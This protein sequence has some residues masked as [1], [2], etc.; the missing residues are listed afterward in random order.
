MLRRIFFTGLAAIIP[1]VITIYIVV[2]LFNFADGILGKFINRYLYE[3]FG[4]RIP[5]LGIII[6]ILTIFLAGFILKLSRM[7]IARGLEKLFCKI[8]IVKSVYFPIKRIVDFLFLQQP[9]RFKGV[10]LVEY[11]RKGIYSIGFVTNENPTQ[12]KKKME[13]K[14]YNIFIP[15][16]PSPL[17]GFTII[18]PEEEIIFLDI[19]I[20]EA[21][22][23]VVS[24]GMIGP[25]E[26][27]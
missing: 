27:I 13:K 17:T 2:G 8:P 1:L 12:F 24:G 25:E 20:E 21:I 7:R 9:E 22:K 6:S 5:G 11:P 14:L 4:Y 23:V 16:S 26:K 15:S 10:V 18:V 3:N 19:T